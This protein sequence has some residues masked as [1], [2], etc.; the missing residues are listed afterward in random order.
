MKTILCLASFTIYP[1]NSVIPRSAL[2]FSYLP[3]CLS[4]YIFPHEVEKPE[5]NIV[6]G[7]YMSQNR[8]AEFHVSPP[9]SN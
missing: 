2:D 9:K 5:V 8:I 7:I 3:M 1:E 6:T 4:I